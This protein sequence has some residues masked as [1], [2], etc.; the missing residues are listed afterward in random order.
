ML[1]HQSIIQ[2]IY[3]LSGRL[4]PTA[5]CEDVWGCCHMLNMVP[6][7]NWWFG[8][9]SRRM[10]ERIHLILRDKVSILGVVTTT[11]WLIMVLNDARCSM[12]MVQMWWEISHVRSQNN[13]IYSVEVGSTLTWLVNSRFSYYRG[14]G[15]VIKRPEATLQ[16]TCRLWSHYGGRKMHGWLYSALIYRSSMKFHSIVERFSHWARC[17]RSRKE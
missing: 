3:Y 2:L 17:R 15:H 10:L 9:E 6:I 7:V 11:W 4:W 12:M 13:L 14:W 5:R 1:I 16:T 8:G